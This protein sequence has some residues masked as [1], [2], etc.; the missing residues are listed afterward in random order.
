MR[1]WRSAPIILVKLGRRPSASADVSE[2]KD[3]V[4]RGY[5]LG[6]AVPPDARVELT[7]AEVEHLVRMLLA[8]GERG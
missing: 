6:G 4:G 5:R 8:A 3:S 1:F 2:E 7:V